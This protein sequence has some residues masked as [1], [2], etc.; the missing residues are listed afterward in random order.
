MRNIA[1]S[2]RQLRLVFQRQEC[3]C[4]AGR[5]EARIHVRKAYY[6]SSAYRLSIHAET[7][8]LGYHTFT[9]SRGL[10]VGAASVTNGGYSLF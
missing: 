6:H 4:S 10:S 2:L 3:V 1:R 8:L 5:A 9:A 7:N